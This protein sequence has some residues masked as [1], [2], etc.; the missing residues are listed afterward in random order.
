MAGMIGMNAGMSGMAGVRGRMMAFRNGAMTAYIRAT[1]EQA[2]KIAAEA[3]RNLGRLS[4]GETSGGRSLE[5]GIDVQKI[6]SKKWAVYSKPT[7]RSFGQSLPVYVEFGHKK[8]TPINF[9][10][11]YFRQQGVYRKSAGPSDPIPYFRK[12]LKG[13]TKET[14]EN[15]KGKMYSA[16]GLL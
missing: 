3:R 8:I 1:K 5:Q 14:I 4:S 12:A 9:D 11:L 15:I 2:E 13:A 16:P 10:F 7:T 6:G